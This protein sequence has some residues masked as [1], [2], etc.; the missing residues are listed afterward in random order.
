MK[1]K[2]SIFHLFL[3][4]LLL[5]PLAADQCF[6]KNP[7]L[8][9]GII[10][11]EPTGISIK[12]WQSGKTAIDAAIAW[13]LGNES[14]FHFHADYLV[15]NFNA[16]QVEKNKIPLY[17]GIGGRIKFE[18]DSKLGIRFPLGTTFFFTDIPLDFFMEIVPILN[19]APA[20]EF[21]LNAALGMHFY[22]H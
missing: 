6:A 13:S 18:D 22:F 17:Y 12:S 15:H 1:I 16:F 14:S 3:A 20:T 5:L 9:V 21:D 11:G 2:N 4:A 19:L 10:L 8:G 7:G